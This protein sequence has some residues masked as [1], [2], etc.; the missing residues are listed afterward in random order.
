MAANGDKKPADDQKKVVKPIDGDLKEKAKNLLL[1]HPELVNNAKSLFRNENGNTIVEES[2]IRGNK[3]PSEIVNQYDLTA[4]DINDLVKEASN[5]IDETL[6]KYNPLVA[7]EDAL[8][9]A[10]WSMG[11]GKFAA[12]VNASTYSL[13]LEAMENASM[14]K[15]ASDNSEG[16]EDGLTE[17][18]L[19]HLKKME[20]GK[21]TGLGEGL[22][23]PEVDKILEERREKNDSVPSD[24]PVEEVEED[25]KKDKPKDTKMDKKAMQE[26]LQEIAKRTAALTALLAKEDSDD[27][28][29]ED[30]PNEGANTK[31]AS[32]KDIVAALEVVAGDLEAENDSELFKIAYQID[33]ICDVLEGKEGATLLGDPD[34][35]YMKKY[36][37]GDV[38]KSDSDEGYMKHDMQGDDTDQIKGILKKKASEQPPYQVKS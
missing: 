24:S 30:A 14:S 16:E 28:S 6:F 12:K 23:R 10:V 26:E 15:K 7:R 35:A 21:V 22:K 4:N 11:E 33:S 5:N 32:T 1:R 9:K 25:T 37:K 20:E 3:G 29:D 34:E 18:Q 38:L 31:V 2:V 13:I 19:T 27:D 17:K 8:T 36:F